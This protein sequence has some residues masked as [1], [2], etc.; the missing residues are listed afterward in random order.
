MI[1]NQAHII[2]KLAKIEEISFNGIPTDLAEKNISKTAPKIKKQPSANEHTIS[3]GF[4]KG[5]LKLEFPKAFDLKKAKQE[6]ETE[7]NQLKKYIKGLE[8]KLNNKNF[9]Q[10]APKEIVEKEQEKLK[11]QRQKLKD[12]I[13]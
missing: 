11:N 8:S 6:L 3:T 9:V 10:K 4:S 5:T 12:L 7:I 13:A 1:Q 2:R